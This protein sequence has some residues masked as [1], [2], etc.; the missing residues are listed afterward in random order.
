MKS[1]VHQRDQYLSNPKRCYGA[2]RGIAG[3]VRRNLLPTE[4]EAYYLIL[5]ENPESASNPEM[6]KHFVQLLYKARIEQVLTRDFRKLEKRRK[7]EKTNEFKESMEFRESRK[8]R[9]RKY[10]LYLM[11]TTMKRYRDQLQK[12]RTFRKTFSVRE[13]VPFILPK[14][15][16]HLKRIDVK[17]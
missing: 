2:F 12:E 1:L 3:S 8:E 10:K 7:I 13:F 5:N 14:E 9:E 4:V 15:V 17:V 16:V 6:F 11:K